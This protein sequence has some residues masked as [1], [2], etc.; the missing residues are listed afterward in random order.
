MSPVTAIRQTRAVIDRAM[1]LLG[2]AVADQL[3]AHMSEWGTIAALEATLSAII[4]ALEHPAARTA[5]AHSLVTLALDTEAIL[6]AA[7]DRGAARSAQQHLRVSEGL[8]RLR[9]IG[10]TAELLDRVCGEVVR[11]C[12]L[13]RAVLSR[14]EDGIWHPWMA[15]FDG[16]P[17]LQRSFTEVL[18]G[19]TIDLADAPVERAVVEERAPRIVNDASGERAYGPIIGPSRSTCYVV[20][21][22][23]SAGRV[24]GLL[25]ADCHPDRTT[26]DDVDRDIVWEFADGFARIYERTELAERLAAQRHFIRTTFESLESVDRKSVV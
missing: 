19:T 5:D 21:P 22:I 15:H 2:P 13:R 1:E 12:G 20:A 25:H 3:G 11:S 23:V 4:D 7:M 24:I 17:D 26:V 8:S 6:V 18:R 14:I 10:C 16:D 9:G